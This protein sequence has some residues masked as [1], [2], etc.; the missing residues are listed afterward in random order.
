MLKA[1]WRDDTGAVLSTELILLMTVLG[2]G[3]IVGLATLR[4]ALVLKLADVADAVCN[5]DNGPRYRQRNRNRHK[6]DYDDHRRRRAGKNGNRS[7]LGDGTNPG[8]GRGRG[9]SPNRGTNNPNRS[10]D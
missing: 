6:S 7:G 5:I 8:R 2:I 3:I 4:N 1:L 9:N 10:G